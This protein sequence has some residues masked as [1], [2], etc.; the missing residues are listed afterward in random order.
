[1]QGTRLLSIA[2]QMETLA[3]LAADAVGGDTQAT[4]GSVRIAGPEGFGS[5]FLA[6]RLYRLSDAH[7]GLNVQ[8]LAG[9]SIYSLSKRDADIVIALSVPPSGRV[10][11]KKLTD[12]ELGLY[13]SKQYLERCG[14]IARKSDL[15][16]HK[17]IGY[18]GD[19]IQMPELD[20]AHQVSTGVVTSLES[21]NLV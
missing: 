3:I 1:V 7:P 10:V 19:L 17:F 6:P 5:Y 2:E 9:S 4:R 18:I 20:Y 13:A 8:L 21:S 11:A 16:G 14:A 12:Y 15:K